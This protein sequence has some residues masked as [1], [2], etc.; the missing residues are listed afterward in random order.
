M[1]AQTSLVVV[2]SADDALRVGKHKRQIEGVTQ[3][4]VDNMITVIFPENSHRFLLI[5]KCLQSNRQDEVSE[6]ASTCII[7]PPAPRDLQNENIATKHTNGG[8]A[9]SSY[10]KGGV[11]SAHSAIAKK[12]KISSTD[13]DVPKA[14]MIR[15]N[16]GLSKISS[17]PPR[18]GM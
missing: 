12:R 16:D 13:P 9:L 2:G 1:Q 17:V 7:N 15:T 5:R 3:T 4:M 14:K 18:K 11:L 8:H 10:N 6:F